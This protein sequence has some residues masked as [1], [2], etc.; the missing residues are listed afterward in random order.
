VN[1]ALDLLVVFRNVDQELTVGQLAAATSLHKSTVSRMAAA[2]VERSFLERGEIGLKL[3]PEVGRLGSLVTRPQGLLDAAR[4]EMDWLAQQT[5][6]TV[7]VIVR[8]GD[9]V[10][11]VA[12][13]EGRHLVGV[14]FWVG[15]RTAIHASAAGKVLLAYGVGDVPRGKLPAF[16]ERTITNREQLKRELAEVRERGWASVAGELEEGLNTVASPIFGSA[17][18]AVASFAVSGPAYRLTPERYPAVAE[19]A[20]DAAARVSAALSR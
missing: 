6:E 20:V 5:G 4:H 17:G 18:E 2:L 1:R 15:R 13:A 11:S 19:A 7:N 9:E 14:G 3:G 16:T 8:S 12:Q 10:V